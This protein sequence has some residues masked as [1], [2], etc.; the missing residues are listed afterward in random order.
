MVNVFHFLKLIAGAGGGARVGAVRDEVSVRCAP[1]GG[2]AARR[3][4][5]LCGVP[6]QSRLHSPAA[7]PEDDRGGARLSALSS[8]FFYFFL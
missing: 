7:T 1:H 2:A 3:P 8:Y 4:E 6:V 5:R